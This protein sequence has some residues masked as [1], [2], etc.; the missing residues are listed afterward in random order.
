[1]PP[2]LDLRTHLPP[3]MPRFRL[4]RLKITPLA[5]PLTKA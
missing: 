5:S 2:T 1:M 4:N 3:K